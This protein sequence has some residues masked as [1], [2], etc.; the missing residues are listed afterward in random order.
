MAKQPKNPLSPEELVGLTSKGTWYLRMIEAPD[1]ESALNIMQI[2][3]KYQSSRTS[4]SAWT[5]PRQ[6]EAGG[7]T[8]R[9]FRPMWN[10][11]GINAT[12]SSLRVSVAESSGTD[13]KIGHVR[14]C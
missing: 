8:E 1:E 11:R 14:L 5:H 2:D 7:W 3:R 12:L 4:Q 6:L 13:S 10:S 9:R